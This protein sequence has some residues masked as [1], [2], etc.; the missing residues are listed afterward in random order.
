[1]SV[2][3]FMQT[4][5]FGLLFSLFCFGVYGFLLYQMGSHLAYKRGW[6]DGRADNPKP[7]VVVITEYVY[8]NKRIARFDPR[9]PDVF[10]LIDMEESTIARILRIC[11]DALNAE[12]RKYITGHKEGGKD[13]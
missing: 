9:V 6:K 4:K 3:E 7:E 1:M 13:A 2:D 11:C 5:F 12:N 8:D 10:L